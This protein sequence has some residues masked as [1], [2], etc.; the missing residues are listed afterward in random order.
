[1]KNNNKEQNFQH[2]FDESE[3]KIY[4]EGETY[5][6]VSFQT[7]DKNNIS[8][9]VVDRCKYYRITNET[10]DGVKKW[11]NWFDKWSKVGIKVKEKN[12][13]YNL[14]E[15]FMVIPHKQEDLIEFY[16]GK[17]FVRNHKLFSEG[18]WMCQHHQYPLCPPS[19]LSKLVETRSN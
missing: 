10:L 12:D 14:V 4:K 11:M 1:M 2:K 9:G 15:D 18:N 17:S 16:H 3:K 13:G 5:F 8:E 7:Y 6:M 19:Y